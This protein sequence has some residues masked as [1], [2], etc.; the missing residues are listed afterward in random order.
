LSEHSLKDI[1]RNL[2]EHYGYIDLALSIDLSLI[3]Q[4]FHNFILTFNNFNIISK[5]K[6]IKKLKK[7]QY[8]DVYPEKP[9]FLY[10]KKS[11]SL[12]LIRKILPI[13]IDKHIF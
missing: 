4:L 1:R 5:I 8:F 10:L 13:F 9:E 6:S 2:M 3:S 12:S 7:Q 11:G